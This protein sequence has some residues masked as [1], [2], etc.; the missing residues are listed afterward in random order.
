MKAGDEELL[1][2]GVG[3]DVDGVGDALEL[4]EGGACERGERCIRTFE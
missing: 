2:G 3:S 1:D 4:V